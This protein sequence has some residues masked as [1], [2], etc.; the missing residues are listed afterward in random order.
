VLQL[1]QQSRPSDE[2][3]LEQLSAYLA[4]HLQSFSNTQSL[5]VEQFAGGASNLTY[6]LTMDH[7]DLILRRPPTGTKAKSAHDMQR[8][9][10]TLNTIAEF[11]T[12]S[13]RPVLLCLDE[14]IIGEQFFIMQ[15][16]DGLAIDKKLPV[17]MTETEINQLC[18][19]YVDG[20][21]EL[22][23]IDI[24]QPEIA[25]L[26]KPK[27]YVA[28]Q[29]NGW[30]ER[31]SKAKT[32]DVLSSDTLYRWLLENL[33]LDSQHEA[34]IHNDYKFD[35]LVLDKNK[36]EEI[37][38]VLDWEMS[39]LGDPLLDLGCS[40]AYWVEASDPAEMHAIRMMPTHLEGMM[41]RQQVFDYYCEK[42]NLSNIQLLPYYV[43]GLFRLAAIAQ[44]I[45]YRYYHGQTDNPKF[46]NFASLVNILIKGA[47]QK[48]S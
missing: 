15:P 42:R 44:Q 4:T 27:G 21:V 23:E 12:L 47:E 22:H 7:Q 20:L 38:G 1:T 9:Y 26:G 3:P 14:S 45:Y 32:D 46:K 25:A 19:N 37:I 5:H 24:N 48:I 33:P 10:T 40:L 29:L 6:R 30:Q 41:T 13:P 2:L 39:T 18:E 16:I 17:E 36:P 31:Y 11:Y 34:L 43:F 35:N 28:R 8:E